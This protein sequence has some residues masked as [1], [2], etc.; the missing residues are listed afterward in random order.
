MVPVRADEIFVGGWKARVCDMGVDEPTIE[1]DRDPND[2][3]VLH[4]QGYNLALGL[5]NLHTQQQS[6]L[7]LVPKHMKL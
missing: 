6:P 2:T 5:V 7:S 1:Q 4:R 3:S